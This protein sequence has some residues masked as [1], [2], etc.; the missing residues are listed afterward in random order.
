MSDEQGDGEIAQ[1]L[2]CAEPL[3]QACELVIAALR[4]KGTV[5]T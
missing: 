5:R 2:G 4:E 3:S 1:R